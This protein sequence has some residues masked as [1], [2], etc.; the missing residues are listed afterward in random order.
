MKRFALL[1]ALAGS[2][3]TFAQSDESTIIKRDYIDADNLKYI[4]ELNGYLNTLGCTVYADS[5]E[6]IIEKGYGTVNA[7]KKKDAE[8]IVL[9]AVET[10]KQYLAVKSE[11][12]TTFAD[13]ATDGAYYLYNVG[14]KEWL[15]SIDGQTVIDQ[16]GDQF[17]VAGGMI[18]EWTVVPANKGTF[19]IKAGENALGYTVGTRNLVEA[20][21]E[22]DE[23]MLVSAAD[24][25]AG[26]TAATA[27]A[28]VD[29][30]FLIA[31]PGFNAG[32]EAWTGAEG[33]IAG[34][35]DKYV[36]TTGTISQEISGLKPGQ[37]KVMVQAYGAGTLTANGAAVAIKAAAD[38]T[39][40]LWVGEE[41]GH[42]VAAPDVL[43]QAGMYWNMATAEVAAD[44]KLTISIDATAE[45]NVDNFRLIAIEVKD[46]PEVIPGDANSDGE[47]DIADVTLTIDYAV[48]NNP[49]GFN[50]VAADVNKDGEI[51]IAD[52]TMI[53]SIIVGE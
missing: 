42:N 14:T 52:V 38:E 53:I 27:E 15:A 2:L 41:W 18:G 46:A 50:A 35:E 29:A 23:W 51:D 5:L 26:I 24:R 37:Y 9:R 8:P 48:G 10:A 49:E 45:T 11:T 13:E 32:A 20:K 39:A 6:M 21:A 7:Y 25:A 17:T 36:T 31:N 19:A 40:P 12:P 22:A 16:P 34:Y 47:V 4:T 30:S 43:F 3:S 33:C 44:G 1:V 28:P